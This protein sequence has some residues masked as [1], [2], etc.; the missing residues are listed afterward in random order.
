MEII[1]S[2]KEFNG[3]NTDELYTI[4][5]LR[6]E[7][8]VVEQNCPYQDADGKDQNA[9]HCQLRN[10]K[11]ILLAYCRIFDQNAYFK[12]FTAIGRVIVNPAFRRL[13]LG[14]KLMEF[15]KKE[16]FRLFGKSAIKI[17]AQQYLIRFYEDLGFKNIGPDYLE[18][19]IPHTYMI[20][21]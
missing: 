20:Y 4:L 16:C 15:A 17:G 19:G 9:Y 1:Y 5:S 8:F 11:G 21:K 7:V 6:Q 10:E 14:K 12:E 2:T 13:E 18:D 3:L